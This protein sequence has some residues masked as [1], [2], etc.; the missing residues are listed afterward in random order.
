M[1]NSATFAANSQYR[2]AVADVRYALACRCHALHSTAFGISLCQRHTS[3]KQSNVAHDNDKLKRIGH[4]LRRF[5]TDCFAQ[6]P[7]SV[8]VDADDRNTKSDRRLK[9][10]KTALAPN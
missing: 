6:F 5:G 7:F 8:F 2:N 1:H 3:R 9:R 4:P 10:P